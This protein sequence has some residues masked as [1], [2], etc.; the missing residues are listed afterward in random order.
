MTCAESHKNTTDLSANAILQFVKVIS[1]WMK[2][3]TLEEIKNVKVL[4][5]YSTNRQMKETDLSC[6]QVRIVKE[7]EIQNHFLELLQLR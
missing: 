2:E 5:C 3:E 6:L 7:G 4:C 1:D